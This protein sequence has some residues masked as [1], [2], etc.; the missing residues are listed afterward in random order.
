MKKKL[1]LSTTA[2]AVLASTIPTHVAPVEAE[3]TGKNIYTKFDSSVGNNV[4]AGTGEENR[5][6]NLFKDAIEAA[7]DG[8]TIV[9]VDKGFINDGGGN[10][11]FHIDKAVTI[12]AGTNN[13]RLEVNAAGIILG[14]DVTFENIQLNFANP[15]HDAIFANGHT[16]NLI[17]V[18]RYEKARE[19]DLFAGGLYRLGESTPLYQPGNN[20]VINVSTDDTLDSTVKSEFGNIYAGSMNGNFSG[21]AEINVSR[22][23]D[24]K[25]LTVKGIYGSGALEA[26]V[27]D[28]WFEGAEP[29]PPLPLPEQ[30][31][32]AG[33]VVVSLDDY[34]V[35]IDGTTGF[36]DSV[37]VETRTKNPNT[38]K[39]KNINILSVLEGKVNPASLD[40]TTPLTSINNIHVE[41]NAILDLTGMTGTFT[42]NKY[43]GRGSV[44]LP[45]KGLTL[46]IT[47]SISEGSTLN[48]LLDGYNPI[49]GDNGRV[50][51]DQVY[52]TT[53]ADDEPINFERH[54][55][56]TKYELRALDKGSHF[57]WT[58]VDPKKLPVPGEPQPDPEEPEEQEPT[59][60]ELQVLD[61]DTRTMSV[62]DFDLVNLTT[63]D[64][65]LNMVTTPDL[66]I[67]TWLDEFNPTV[68][69]GDYTA[70]P[71]KDNLGY[72]YYRVDELDVTIYF[73]PAND[74]DFQHQ[75]MKVQFVDDDGTAVSPQ[76]LTYEFEISTDSADPLSLSLTVNGDEGIE[77]GDTTPAQPVITDLEQVDKT[78]TIT[79]GG[80]KDDEVPYAEFEFKVITDPPLT[81]STRFDTF[82][83][84]VVIDSRGATKV[85]DGGDITYRAEDSNMTIYFE[86]V[87]GDDPSLQKMVVQFKDENGMPVDLEDNE[88]SITIN[89]DKTYFLTFD[90]TVNEGEGE[91]KDPILT[92][93][94]AV[95]DSN[96]TM[97]ITEFSGDE[98][99]TIEYELNMQTDVPIT[100]EFLLS[101]NSV[102]LAVNNNVMTQPLMADGKTYYYRNDDLDLSVYFESIDDNPQGQKMIVKFEDEDGNP[103]A[104]TQT[105]Y[106]IVILHDGISPLALSLV[107]EPVEV[108]PTIPVISQFNVSGATKNVDANADFRV[109]YPFTVVGTNNETDIDL[110]NY[111]LEFNF[112]GS[113]AV[114]RG[115]TK[116]YYIADSD[117]TVKVEKAEGDNAYKLVVTGNSSEL[118]EGNHQLKM[119]VVDGE[120]TTTFNLNVDEPEE[121]TPTT[122]PTGTVTPEPPIVVTPTV[123]SVSFPG[124][125]TTAI[126]KLSQA[127]MILP[128]PFNLTFNRVPTQT[129]GFETLGYELT[130]NGKSAVYDKSSSF[131][132][133]EGESTAVQIVPTP[134]GG[135]TAKLVNSTDGVAAQV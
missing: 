22:L 46:N 114:Y 128:L 9:I 115:D 35:P 94:T 70:E 88:Y 78:K 92:G 36:N 32:M 112:D 55:A 45:T 65:T 125:V 120:A 101:N 53:P 61:G 68:K 17:N 113:N 91:Y 73:E 104:P 59:L 84:E 98:Q 134:L 131:Y 30:F 80:F 105:T 50:T 6:F 20:G 133:V 81:E 23:N 42:T 40:G 79:A 118:K 64:Y 41:E 106:S 107:V 10:L 24:S 135:Y 108:K 76:A 37:T 124:D 18:T 58:A 127:P 39:L 83:P 28:N 116:D 5:P 126:A 90:L 62:G 109:E 123:V 102:G 89:I 51:E 52:I 95:G 119:G 121:V 47:E 19:I 71:V 2:I 12:V 43:T 66:E 96:K 103:V 117:V 82:N 77:G 75:K 100:N 110:S 69:V 34:Q 132:R 129:V 21:D 56:D 38:L 99:P 25:K 97:S 26:T 111:R 74:G 44:V 1:A 48:L 8:D 11:P 29:E 72:I 57:E 87:E 3:E 31:K 122:P 130:I 16:L 49:R 85:G 27:S 67:D 93:L 54:Y 86:P 60:T 7:K 13:A 15:I 63:V 4:S 14:K 33:D